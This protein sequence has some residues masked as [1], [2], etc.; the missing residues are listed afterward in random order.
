MNAFTA[1]LAREHAKVTINACCPGWVQTDMGRLV[2]KPP[3]SDVDGA[4]IPVRLAFGDLG[5]VSGR[6]WANDGVRSKEE[7]KVQEW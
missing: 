5:G 6:Y 2:G 3:K 4:K 7:G 1:V